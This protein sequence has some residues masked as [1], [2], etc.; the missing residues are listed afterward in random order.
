MHVA[1]RRVRMS[2][3]RQS[4]PARGQRAGGQT[5]KT[6]ACTWSPAVSSPRSTTTLAMR[7]R[8]MLLAN[9]SERAAVAAAA[10]V[11]VAVRV[12]AREPLRLRA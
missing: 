3:V 12:V 4:D 8:L 7:L 11:A 6:S 5:S 1:T 10:A 9:G 2:F